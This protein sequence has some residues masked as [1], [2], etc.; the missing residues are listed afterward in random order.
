M[1]APPVLTSPYPG[2]VGLPAHY[3]QIP[4]TLTDTHQAEDGV[5]ECFRGNNHQALHDS[6]ITPALPVDQPSVPIDERA[7]PIDERAVPMLET[8]SQPLPAY[9]GSGGP[10]LDPCP[11]PTPLQTGLLAN[12]AG[13]LKSSIKCNNAFSLQPMCAEIAC[14]HIL[15]FFLFLFFLLFFDHLWLWCSMNAMCSTT[16][17]H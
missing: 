5:S 12:A 4:M 7:V 16:F 6:S 9:H 3:L 10:C 15:L 8:Q 2:Q 14:Y 11:N 1:H 13:D 17:H